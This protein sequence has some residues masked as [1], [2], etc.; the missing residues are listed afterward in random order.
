MRLHYSGSKETV[1]TRMKHLAFGIAQRLFACD[2]WELAGPAVEEAKAAAK[3]DVDRAVS[4]DSHT[5]WQQPISQ[6]DVQRS[7]DFSRQRA[8]QAR[9]T[10]QATRCSADEMPASDKVPPQRESPMPSFPNG[11]MQPR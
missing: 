4:L 5:L 1:S 9:E 11:L 8:A 7:F 3:L 2:A 10:Q 6:A